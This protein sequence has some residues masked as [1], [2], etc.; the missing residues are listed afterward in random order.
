MKDWRK[1]YQDKVKLP[2]EAVKIVKSGDRVMISGAGA[3]PLTTMLALQ[4]RRD[5]LR[6]VKVFM[7]FSLYM[8]WLQPGWE[9]SFSLSTYFIFPASAPAIRERRMEYIPIT[10]GFIGLP[11]SPYEG[12]DVGIIKVTPPNS[13]GYCSFGPEIWQGPIIAKSSAFVIGEVYP[14]LVW[15][16]PEKVH[17][18]D[19]DAL[20]ETNPNIN[21]RFSLK[22]SD[23][24]KIPLPPPDEA[25]RASV[26]GVHAADLIN[27]GDTIQ[28]GTGTASEAIAEMLGDK[29]DLGIDTELVPP[30][31][32]DLIKNGIVTNKRKNQNRGKTVCSAVYTYE[33]DPRTPEILEYIN[34]NSTFELRRV[35]YICNIP[36]IA[37]N[38][39]QVAIN[40][41]LGLDLLGQ[42]MI[43]HRATEPQSGIGGQFDYC[44]GAQLSNGGRSITALLSVYKQ[45]TKSRIVPQFETGTVIGL[46]CYC[47]EYLVT[48]HGIV[49][50]RGKTRRERAQAIISIA[51]P[52]F[53]EELESAA[54][55]LFWQRREG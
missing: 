55:K 31:T 20:V 19:I 49:N 3:N 24:R 52:K 51:E 8:P 2:E 32:F 37:R 50:L 21:E 39:N 9:N 34:R 5:E 36:R 28:I 13:R 27:D 41:A 14:D 6:N 4:N 26:V 54:E 46:P 53:K 15:T 35:D 29:N 12:A 43:D 23:V 7:D 42:A 10:S 40:T 11:H 25:E 1:V 45:G 33:D 16:Y 18:S 47:I 44:I 22:T 30:G 48:E 38:N 17:I